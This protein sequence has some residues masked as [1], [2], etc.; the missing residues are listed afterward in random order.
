MS[1]GETLENC[2]VNAPRVA[3]AVPP[4]STDPQP[5]PRAVRWC[6]RAAAHAALLCL[7]CSPRAPF[8][9]APPLKPSAAA[10]SSSRL[11]SLRAHEEELRVS[12]DP[13]SQPPWVD[14]SGADPYRIALGRRGFVGILRGSRALV[15]LD[16]ELTELGRAS[17]PENPTALCVS[18][19]VA[20]TASRYG[21]YVQRA[22][23]GADGH[24]ELEPARELGIAG[25][26][27]VACGEAGQVYVLPA[28]GTELLVLDAHGRKLAAFPALSG[29]LRL[30]RYGRY[31][32]E[33]SL[34]ERSLRVLDLDARGLPVRERGRVHHDGTL[35]AFDAL[36][37]GSE[38][39]LAVA[40]VEDRPLVRAHGEFE[41]IDSYV[42]IY[43]LNQ[44]GSLREVA[45]LDVSDSGLVVPKAVLLR[46]AD[47]QLELTALAS[48]SGRL[49][50]AR[51]DAAGAPASLQVL[52]APPGV[53]DALLAP[54]GA[55]IVYA[56]PLLDAF[57]KASD[58]HGVHV[59]HVDPAL[60]PAPELRLGEALFF[61]ELMAP[62]NQSQG[63]HSRFTCET[64]HFEGGVD[65]RTHYTGRADVRVVTKPLLGLANNRPHFSRA[66]DPDLSS[67]CHNEFRVAGAGSGTDP[68]F[69]LETAR[70]PWLRELGIDRANLTALEL[71]Q[72]L[73]GFFYTFTH[74]PNPSRRGR[75]GLTEPERK[76]AEV[77]RQHCAQCHRPRLVTDDA[78][79]EQPF[80][81]WESLVLDRRAP[82]VWASPS[83]AKTGV[84]PY[85]HAQGTRVTSLRRL[86]L[87]PRF[88]TSGAALQLRDVLAGFRERPDQGALHAGEGGTPLTED[89]QRVLLAFL[90]LL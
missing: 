60:A 59:R 13:A 69:T 66:L 72:A 81:R 67:V 62:E 12:F 54:N 40:G 6:A 61:T 38:L 41:N 3:R 29:G 86:S 11:R 77:F 9:E 21:G 47:E 64:C 75:S 14:A 44:G 88:F 5:L 68:W 4:S 74:A 15:T 17:L 78:G 32:I 42:W 10:V 33:L 65:G 39:L 76:G 57:V 79:T 34:F 7:A 53:S 84:L 1:C 50:H 36:D 82:L 8:A 26:A 18:D 16:Q 51:F 55:D 63:S 43:A 73:L 70:F 24:I 83:Y 71:R 89:E 28:D 52:S 2:A 25:V 23:L 49:L 19:D 22:R 20:W 35:W 80:E 48:G 90:R 27:D 87:K 30:R 31:L 56:S 85:V 37:D 58:R 45:A 46:R